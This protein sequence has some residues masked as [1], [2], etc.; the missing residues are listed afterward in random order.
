MK[1]GRGRSFEEQDSFKELEGFDGPSSHLVIEMEG[2]RQNS[3]TDDVGGKPILEN[4]RVQVIAS[5]FNSDGFS[6]G[7]GE[8]TWMLGF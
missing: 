1:T 3:R 2:R 4:A 7:K 5:D 6:L 8:G